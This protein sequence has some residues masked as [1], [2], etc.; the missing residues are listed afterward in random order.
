MDCGKI[1]KSLTN[2]QNEKWKK[3]FNSGLRKLVNN[4]GQFFVQ[5][6]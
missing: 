2:L 3:M 5:C 4:K 1:G 6:T